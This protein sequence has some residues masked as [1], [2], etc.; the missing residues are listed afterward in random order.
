M[1]I[2]PLLALP[3]S[4]CYNTHLN[5]L[6]KLLWDRVLFPPTKMESSHQLMYELLNHQLMAWQN[7]MK[8]RKLKPR[9]FGNG[10]VDKRTK[11]GALPNVVRYYISSGSGRQMYTLRMSFVGQRGEESVHVQNLSTDL[12][13]AI[14][15]AH[16]ITGA[17]GVRL[18]GDKVENEIER[19]DY[20]VFQFG[21][22]K[23]QNVSYVIVHDRNYCEWFAHN[24]R[25]KNQ[26]AANY[27]KRL[28]SAAL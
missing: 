13:K 16:K 23:D 7:E 15:K 19:T 17:K 22:Y 24:V 27:V 28:L 18:D 14:K 25:G 26:A 12:D 20:S 6:V 1:D 21:K 5:E 9:N 3:T 11:S 2:P 10:M 4:L 8:R